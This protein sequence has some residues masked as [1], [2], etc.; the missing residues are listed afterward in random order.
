VNDV[1]AA[2][3]DTVMGESATRCNEVRTQR[4]LF[5]PDQQLVAPTKLAGI[6][7][8]VLRSVSIAQPS[9]LAL[10]GRSHSGSS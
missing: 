8:V 4:W 10:A 9:G 5:I 2:D 1:T 6:A 7:A 3:V